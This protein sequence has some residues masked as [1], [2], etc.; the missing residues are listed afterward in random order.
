[1]NS[2]YPF[3]N[4]YPFNWQH[5]WGKHT[6]LKWPHN[7]LKKQNCNISQHSCGETGTVNSKCYVTGVVF[8]H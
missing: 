5:V 3:A 7:Y 1:M 8:L 4:S 6:L 2:M